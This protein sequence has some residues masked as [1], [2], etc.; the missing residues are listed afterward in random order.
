VFHGTKNSRESWAT[1]FAASA[2]EITQ[3]VLLGVLRQ[4][5]DMLALR[6]VG[7]FALQRSVW[8]VTPIMMRPA[9]GDVTAEELSALIALLSNYFT[10]SSAR[11]PYEDGIAVQLYRDEVA[12]SCIR[13]ID[14]FGSLFQWTS[15]FG[16]QHVEATSK[17]G[18]PA[19]RIDWSAT[20]S[21][22]L[23]VISASGVLFHEPVG[24]VNNFYVGTLGNM[25]A[26]A[27]HSLA[28]KY[29]PLSNSI[30]FPYNEILELAADVSLEAGAIESPWEDLLVDEMHSTNRDHVLELVGI[31]QEYAECGKSGR[32]S[33]ASVP[34]MFGTLNFDLVWEDMCRVA[35][36]ADAEAPVGFSNPRYLTPQKRFSTAVQRPD[37]VLY[38]A[39]GTLILDAKYYP[40]FPETFPGL[41]DVRKQIFYGET[42]I[43]LNAGLAFLFP[44]SGDVICNLGRADMYESDT[45]DGRFM[46]IKC[47]GVPWKIAYKAYVANKA[48][49]ALRSCA[50]DLIFQ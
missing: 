14:I 50:E 20:F 47:I 42:Q 39:K 19:G 13:E 38:S 41:E 37:I 33:N 5:G 18:G 49:P 10:R 4:E 45:V 34:A 36:G 40:N 16:I 44:H 21:S 30:A 6:F 12:L 2:V 32:D 23:P 17:A 28:K 22:C 1:F 3:L 26:I 31:L 35:F 7:L 15:M 48:L 25:Q 43:G 24:L 27:L 11:A 8:I 46:C 9:N 29:S